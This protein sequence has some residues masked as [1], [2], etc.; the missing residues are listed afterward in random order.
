MR[1]RAFLTGGFALLATPVWAVNGNRLV[2]KGAMEQGSLA[3]GYANPKATVKID[4]QAVRLSP[5]GVFAFGFA[6]DQTKPSLVEVTW[7]D[8]MIES[9]S[10][11]PTVR[12]YEIQRVNGLPQ[13]TVTPPPDVLERIKREAG[14]IYVARQRDVPGSDFLSGFD[15]PAPGRES[16]VFGSQRIDNGVPMAP[17]FGVDMAAPT[18]TPI[19]APADGTVSLSADHYLNG[20]FTLIDHGQGVSTSY[21]HQSKRLVKDGDVVKRGQKIGEIGQTGRA[22]GPHLHW[23]MNWFEVKLDPSRS[24]RKPKPDLL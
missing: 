3:L 12:Q 5:D 23:A 24:T 8:G 19:H 6:F 18:G 4:G 20:G 13:N 11:T 21:L 1:R 10:Y 9:Q 2:V 7:S 22:T 14:E 15:W 17:H 16:G